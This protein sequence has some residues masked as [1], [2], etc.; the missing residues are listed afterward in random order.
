MVGPVFRFPAD[1]FDLPCVDVALVVE[2][3]YPFLTGGVS[4]VVHDI[5]AHNSDLTFGIIHISWDSATI[6]QD[7]YGMPNNVAWV[8]II[9]LSLNEFRDEF[10]SLVS[11]GKTDA[12]EATSRLVSAVQAFWADNDGPLWELYDDAI[13]PLTRSWQLW[14]VLSST[15]F[16]DRIAQFLPNGDGT[17]LGQ[18]FWTMRDFFTLAYA[19]TDRVQ[20]PARVYH[21]HTQG[22]AAIVAAC[23]ARQYDA[24]FLLTEHNLHIRDTLNSLFG[25]RQDL[26]ITRTSWCDL[27]RTTVERVWLLWWTSISLWAYLAT[28][29]MTYLYPGAVREAQAL[30][31]DGTKT[32][33]LPNGVEWEKFAPVRQARKATVSGLS[34]GSHQHWNLVAI[35]R[36]VPIKGIFE[37]I[38]T[39]A[40]IR[41]RGYNNVSLDILGPL[42]HDEE[43]TEKARDRVAQCGLES[44]VRLRGTQ[45]IPQELH[46]YDV[47]LMSSFNEGQPIVVL[48]A[49]SAGLPII[50][51]EVGGMAMTVTQPLQVSDGSAIG[52]CGRLV[53]PGDVSALADALTEL[54]DSPALYCLFHNNG[55]ERVQAAFLMETA[56]GRYNSV[57]RELGAGTVQ[58]QVER[59]LC[60]RDRQPDPVPTGVLQRRGDPIEVYPGR[61]R[62]LL[63]GGYFKSR[64]P[65]HKRE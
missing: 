11:K 64:R 13:N 1:A 35:S 46:K 50:G 45:N 53:E 15:S 3:T 31:A 30:G 58:P 19:L 52:A 44:V 34:A 4:A 51:T 57:Y 23:G 43:Y 55:F 37:M 20:P 6:G 39:I 42:D 10:L 2:S 32:E 48:E 18:L 16:L 61:K 26:T 62:S 12:E 41:D 28:D 22:Y 65:V 63:G 54:I 40:V 60:M 9:Y 47:L 7:I 27:P 49:M 17:S 38:E 21:S 8:D 33:I 5:I 56:M 59:R 25:R 29:H 24:K 36:V 14:P